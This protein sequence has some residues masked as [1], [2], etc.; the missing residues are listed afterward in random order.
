MACDPDG[1]WSEHETTMTFDIAPAYY[2]TAWFRALCAAGF[3]VLLWMMYQL[4]LRQLAREFNVRLEERVGERTRIARELHDTLLQSFQASLVQMQAARTLLSRRPEQ[5]LGTLD[6]AVSM[7]EGAIAEG[8]DAIQGLRSRPPGGSDF[9]KL[10]TLTGQ[11]LAASQD[12]NGKPV[13]FRVAVEGEQRNLEPLIQ[14]GA[15]RIAR[16][17]LRN[18][19]QH[20]NASKIEAEIRYEDRLFRLHIRD[21]GKGIE[22]KILKAGGPAGHWGLLGMR[23]RAKRSGGRLEIWSQAGAGTEVELSIP[24]SIAYVAARNG[25]RFP[26][27]NRKK[28]RS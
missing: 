25:R 10:L 5:A 16:E 9:A 23:E 13:T 14:D 18:A 4:R 12:K 17:L 21:N 6:Q 2:Q 11:E 22:P 24:G 15:Y 26:L 1:R 7:T 19:F 28:A 3:L 20:A 8:R 27:F